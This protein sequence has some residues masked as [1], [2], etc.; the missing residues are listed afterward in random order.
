MLI[1][2]QGAGGAGGKGASFA[3]DDGDGGGAGG[4]CMLAL[5][6]QENADYTI[7]V[8]SGGANN[9]NYNTTGES[10]GNTTLCCNGDAIAVAYGG[11]GGRNFNAPGKGG[12]A[13]VAESVYVK[14]IA[15]V[16]GGSGGDGDHNTGKG[17]SVEAKTISLLAKGSAAD[18]LYWI[19]LPGGVSPKSQAGTEGHDIGYTG[20]GG[21]SMLA[22]GGA[23]GDS[24]VDIPG[25]NG[26]CGSGGGGGRYCFGGGGP[27][28]A[29]GSG[30]A[31]IFY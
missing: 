6:L 27:G 22:D 29:G 16:D 30:D 28:G 18:H 14:R 4:F 12:T 1:A 11:S 20:S 25:K 3:G 31:M 8:G 5:Q 2:L 7:T 17:G 15:C 19:R 10:G 21:G 23:G 26:R 13:T 24:G 9:H